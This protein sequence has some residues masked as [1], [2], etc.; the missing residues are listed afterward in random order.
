MTVPTRE[1]RIPIDAGTLQGD[2]F[3][4]DGSHALVVFVNGR[5]TGRHSVDDRTVATQLH[6][7]GIA[8]LAVDLLTAHEQQSTARASRHAGD[9][10]LLTHRLLEVV[11]WV[12]GDAS[13]KRAALGLCGVADGGVAA[14]IAAARLGGVVQAVVSVGG[15]PDAAGPAVLTA[16]KAPTLLLV[17]SRDTENL[18]RN[19][20]AYQHLRGERSLAVVPGGGPLLEEHGVLAHAGEMAAAWFEFHLSAVEAF[21]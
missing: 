13:L 18:A 19:D 21:A 17:G 14:M 5:G 15:R 12:G 1:V 6:R 11:Q 10:A 7:A 20:S 8:S 2:L 9:P 3:L 16:I 4:P